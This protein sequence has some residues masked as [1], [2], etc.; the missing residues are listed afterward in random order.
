M[1]D[2]ESI[3]KNLL[4]FYILITNYQKEKGRD[5]VYNCIKERKYLGKNL[6][7]KIKVQ[8]METMT[9]MNKTEDDTN[10]RK[11]STCSWIGRINIVKMSIVL[12]AIYRFSAIPI[13][14]P[15]AFFPKIG[16]IT[17]KF[18]WGYKRS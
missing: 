9:L 11:D 4:H 14:I 12:K 1:K 2:A 17:P 6:T 13:K 8:Y 16:E 7:E 15:M 10:K 3:Y 5:R 18:V